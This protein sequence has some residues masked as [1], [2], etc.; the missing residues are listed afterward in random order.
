MYIVGAAE[1]PS[2]CA[3]VSS[4]RRP[5]NVHE[6]LM[7]NR[8]LIRPGKRLVVYINHKFAAKFIKI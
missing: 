3:A 6:K 7:P 2:C 5:H 8:I 4:R 1:A